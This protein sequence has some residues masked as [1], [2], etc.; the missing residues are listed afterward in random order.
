MHSEMRLFHNIDTN[1][2]MQGCCWTN[3]IKRIEHLINSNVF[4]L[5]L[6]KKILNKKWNISLWFVY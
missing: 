3:K 6:L 1:K 5:F 4:F 2:Q